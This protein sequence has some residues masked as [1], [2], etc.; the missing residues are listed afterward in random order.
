MLGGDLNAMGGHSSPGVNYYI[1]SYYCSRAGVG[2][3]R[4]SDLFA[5]VDARVT[6]LLQLEQPFLLNESSSTSRKL[7]PH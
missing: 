3:T 1:V 6:F 5:K 2:L 4:N 7:K